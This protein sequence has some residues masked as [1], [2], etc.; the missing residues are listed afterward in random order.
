MHVAWYIKR[1]PLK[2]SYIMLSLDFFKINP[3]VSSSVG[4]FWF[5]LFL[6]EKIIILA[7]IWKKTPNA[8]KSIERREYYF[9][10]LSLSSALRGWQ[11]VTQTHVT[12]LLLYMRFFQGF[13][14][15]EKLFI[16]FIVHSMLNRGTYFI[17]LNMNLDNG[18][19][20][21]IKTLVN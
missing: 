1:Y 17:L 5:I 3:G 11:T 8:N 7:I 16:L 15:I 10:L 21:W 12:L 4:R 18:R 9:L 2:V 20:I 6:Y 13:L 14:D 19:F